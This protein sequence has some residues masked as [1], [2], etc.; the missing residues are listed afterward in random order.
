MIPVVVNNALRTDSWGI[1]RRNGRASVRERLARFAAESA[2]EMRDGH[3]VL[4]LLEAI[5]GGLVSALQP[6][7]SLVAENL[8]LRQQLA[9]LRVGRRPNLRPI[10]CAHGHAGSRS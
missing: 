7:A 4:A 9:V 5:V 3:G 8:A 1:R 10:A 2:A 6:R